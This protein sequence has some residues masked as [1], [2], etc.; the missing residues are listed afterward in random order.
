MRTTQNRGKTENLRPFKPGQ[1]GN[2][3][4]RPKMP[5]DLKKLA[6]AKAPEALKIAVTLMGKADSDRVRLA[7]AQEV[8]D[9]AYGRATQ[10]IEADITQDQV[11]HLVST[12]AAATR[13]VLVARIGLQNAEL[14]M[15]EIHSRMG[16]MLAAGQGEN[17]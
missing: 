7:A 11:R 8:M 5:E 14:V 4:G 9:R 6:Q 15:T 13:E 12:Q 1:S 16:A 17:K 10:H 2:P 3:S